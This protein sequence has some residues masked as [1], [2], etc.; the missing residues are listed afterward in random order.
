MSSFASRLSM[1]ILF[2]LFFVQHGFAGQS[3]EQFVKEFYSWYLKSDTESTVPERNPDIYKYVAKA[4]ADRLRDDL[5]R[6][7]LP[8]DEGYFTKVQDYSAVEWSANIVVHRATVLSGVVLVPVT[9]GAKAKVDVVLFLKRVGGQWQIIKADD[10][11]PY[12]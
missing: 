9:F 4:T 7:A 1:V 5:Q 11:S 12:P 10:T 2:S 6:G 3:P 8:R